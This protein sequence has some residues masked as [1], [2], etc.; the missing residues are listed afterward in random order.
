MSARVA[1]E[2]LD[3][4][5]FQ[6]SGTLCNLTCHHCFISCS[7]TN[8]SFELMPKEDVF[9]ALDA[10]RGLGVKE[11]Y[12]TGGEPFLHPALIEILERTLELGPASV[13]TNGTLLKPAAIARLADAEASSMYSLE[14]RVS[15]DGHSRE[16]NDAIRGDGS[17]AR[18]MAGVRL[19]LQ[20]GFLPIVT[21]A[22]TWDDSL[23][24]EVF[25]G[26]V[27]LLEDEG[28]SR[29]RIKLIPTLRMGAE[30]DRDRG[31]LEYERVTSAMLDDFDT[32][33][34]LCTRAR[35]VTDKG[36]Y[37]CPI[38]ID[39]PDARLGSELDESLGPFT[40]DH[41]ACYTCYAGGAICSNVSAGAAAT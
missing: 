33:Q 8:H 26:F 4:L 37:V 21:V 7:P 38:L 11:Y 22:Q 14:F 29:P 19:L 20:H 17:F 1:L 23:A 16:L 39:A 12:F 32:S 34:L 25:G 13:L 41:G 3:D 40:L 5:W 15:I 36:V 27:R 28:Y 9:R 35:M 24:D 2:S 6:I 10:S 18:A 31:Y 30:V